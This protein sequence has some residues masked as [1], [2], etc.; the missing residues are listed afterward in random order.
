MPILITLMAIGII[1]LNVLLVIFVAALFVPQWRERALARV[2]SNSRLIVLILSVVSVAGTLLMEYVGL[3][4][5]CLLCWWQ[6]VFMYPIAIVS[7]VAFIKNTDFS[8]IADYVLA[9]SLIGG[10]IALYQHMLQVL[11]SGSL[12]PCDAAGECSKRLV[13]EFGFVTIPWMALSVFAVLIL[14]ALVSRRKM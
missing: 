9:L 1:A 10:A 5:P 7:L 8:E 4:D 6:R 14:V 3:L 11:P 12:L 13:F 2:R